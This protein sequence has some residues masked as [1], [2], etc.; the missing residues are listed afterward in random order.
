MATATAPT[1]QPINRAETRRKIQSP[2]KAVSGLIRTYVCLEGAALALLFLGIW[3]WA[4]LAL[5]YG[6][7]ATE[8]TFGDFV[9]ALH[10]D[11]IKS[12]DQNLINP[13]NAYFVRAGLLVLLL[14]G[15]GTIVA[16]KIFRRLFT[17]FSDPTLAL[18]LEKRFPKR[19]GG[20]LITAVEMVNPKLSEKYG[21]SQD[22]VDHTVQDATRRLEGLNVSP[23]FNWARLRSQWA[24]A[25]LS[26]IGLYLLVL[27]TCSVVGAVTTPND[28]AA[29]AA[30][31]VQEVNRTAW[32]WTKRNVLMQPK[33][34]WPT[35]AYLEVIRVRWSEDSSTGFSVL[36]VPRDQTRPDVVVQ[37]YQWVK[38]DPETRE[39]IRPLMV[40]DLEDSLPEE[41]QSALND[42]REQ[43]APEN[44]AQWHFPQREL[45]PVVSNEVLK[46]LLASHTEV[47]ENGKNKT[48]VVNW[49][50]DDV[51]TGEIADA[52]PNYTE[53]LGTK[54]TEA[55]EKVLDWRNWTYDRLLLQLKS[56]EA[57]TPQ[58]K[59]AK[60]ELEEKGAWE[61]F[62]K[63]K[64]AVEKLASSYSTNWDVRKLQRP[65]RAG[66]VF[67]DGKVV[68]VRSCNV[69]IGN[70]YRVD[71][72]DLP[73][74]A[75][76]GAF[77]IWAENYY[78]PIRLIEFIPPP[79]IAE[80]HADTLQPA[81]MYYNLKTE[82]QDRTLQKSFD[83]LDAVLGELVVGSETEKAA[84]AV[85]GEF[86]NRKTAAKDVVE[87]FGAI[88]VRIFH[89]ARRL[90]GQLAD[91]ADAAE[92]ALPKMTGSKLVRKAQA[93]FQD[94][95]S[96]AEALRRKLNQFPSPA[97]RQPGLAGERQFVRRNFGKKEDVRTLEVP[98]GSSLELVATVE[99]PL[100]KFSLQVQ[101]VDET[102]EDPLIKGAAVPTSAATIDPK[103]EK[104]FRLEIKNIT[105]AY[106]FYVLYSDKDNVNGKQHFLIEPV[107]D[108]PPEEQTSV[109]LDVVLRKPRV[110]GGSANAPEG[111]LVTY[112]AQ[113]PFTG[114]MQDDHGLK[115]LVWLYKV[116]PVDL[117]LTVR[118]MSEFDLP[119]KKE[120]KQEKPLDPLA[121]EY[122]KRALSGFANIPIGVTPQTW[123]APTYW[124]ALIG[125]LDQPKRMELTQ[126]QDKLAAIEVTKSL[127]LPEIRK[128]GKIEATKGRLPNG[129]LLSK[130]DFFRP[131]RSRDAA[132]KFKPP[133]F[134]ISR[135]PFDVG[136]IPRRGSILK[137]EKVV[138][139]K[140][141]S[142]QTIRYHWQLTLQL[143]AVDNNVE[144]GPGI[145]SGRSVFK[146][147]IVSETELNAQIILEEEELRS[148]L[149]T[150]ARQL[151]NARIRLTEQIKKMDL[152]GQDD[153]TPLRSVDVQIEGARKEFSDAVERVQ[154]VRQA[155]DRI[156]DEMYI[157]QFK[158]DRRDH[159]RFR[160]L[161]PL[162]ESMDPNLVAA[163]DGKDQARFPTT[164]AEL[165]SLWNKVAPDAERVRNPNG[166]SNV[167]KQQILSNVA[168]SKKLAVQTK[169]DIENL[170]NQLIR[171]IDQ[172]G[173]GIDEPKLIALLEEISNSQAEQVGQ[174]EQAQ[175]ELIEKL[176]RELT[177][178]L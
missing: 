127:T 147:L 65:D 6:L 139:T 79:V 94:L 119:K 36:R 28:R 55:V 132:M 116:R 161:R 11:W 153:L 75:C 113:I 20:R 150:A 151:K 140:K 112:K 109:Q 117:K 15:I 130:M 178:G 43:L 45:D 24:L 58:A 39:S 17:E 54:G 99:R 72:N 115:D 105:K 106:E 68:A 52:L 88:K 16:I 108:L 78:T 84:A 169:D 120:E 96:E 134:N 2:L 64:K 176:R 146:F 90:A 166:L 145:L 12:L 22:M 159:I 83:A 165:T 3:F 128:Y 173:G 4:G 32:I 46:G 59:K 102:V 47:R 60:A 5:D 137:K 172:I 44:W 143:G 136:L 18:L 126:F 40:S 23:V 34:Y 144:T 152:L 135:D 92:K 100:K 158:K 131:F 63:I 35:R 66:F 93:A 71:L 57:K 7:F 31:G 141:G 67:S 175:K 9:L 156:R 13:N 85:A 26:T 86:W 123:V 48:V 170:R 77:R 174:I 122:T 125:T 56:L 25:V 111:F 74:E 110:E 97:A 171:V 80:L 37:S 38:Y 89:T 129:K 81:Y 107:D 157:N 87:V 177:G 103:N 30:K 164:G 118:S 114:V 104:V 69:E 148:Q 154:K 124:A 61:K 155:Y 101:K 1:K 98:T 82:W 33:V 168:D 51:T 95:H 76:N 42:L 167:V 10:F 91:A 73:E 142:T 41:A 149:E 14:V 29:G 121:W 70:V 49:T 50:N 62:E 133:Q 162:N 53:R 21:Y 163:Q 138:T 8:F 27:L 19:L 160:I